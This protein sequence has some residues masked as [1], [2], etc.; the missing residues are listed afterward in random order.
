MYGL[1]HKSSREWERRAR[2]RLRA[3]FQPPKFTFSGRVSKEHFSFGS[4]A[5]LLAVAEHCQAGETGLQTEGLICQKV[6]AKWDALC[7]PFQGL[8][9]D[10]VGA[11]PCLS[12]TLCYCIEVVGRLILWDKA[13]ICV[14]SGF[15]AA[16][17]H[18]HLNI[19]SL[20]ELY[21]IFMGWELE[22]SK[23]N[24]CLYPA[25]AL[26]VFFPELWFASFLCLDYFHF[27]ALY[28]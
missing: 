23:N 28:T 12:L 6:K 17:L 19:L 10:F 14:A 25:P 15:W 3:S 4:L 9:C 27:K 5:S 26:I 8:R 16:V 22:T 24:S 20:F 1:L 13:V 7:S 11:C 21:L 18:V 2:H